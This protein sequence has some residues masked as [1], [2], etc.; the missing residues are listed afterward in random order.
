LYSIPGAQQYLD[1]NLPL[2]PS[3][4][5]F[6]QHAEL[7]RTD[8]LPPATIEVGS[9][10]IWPW[11]TFAAL[12]VFQASMRK[13]KVQRAHVLRCVI[14][15]A[16]ASVFYTVLM[17]LGITYLVVSAALQNSSDSSNPFVVWLMILLWLMRLDRLAVAYRTYLQF[18]Y[19]FFTVLASQIIVALAMGGLLFWGA[20]L[21]QWIWGT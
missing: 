17:L 8:L 11:L 5:F 12:M 3:R 10:L 4:T 16:D 13:A 9:I 6:Q 2:P 7:L 19:P 20:R 18:H 21:P 15:S 1:A 14:Y